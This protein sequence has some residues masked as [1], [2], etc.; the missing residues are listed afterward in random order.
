EHAPDAIMVF[1]VEQDR[2]IDANAPAEKLF[3]YPRERLLT[4][5]PLDFCSKH[6]ADGRPSCEVVEDENRKVLEGG[7][8]VFE[9]THV[10][11]TGREIACHVRLSRL[12]AVGR[13]LIR[14][15]MTDISELKQLE[16]KV[17]HADRLAAVGALAAGVAH[18]IGNPLMALSM[19]AQSLERRSCD[20]YTQKKLALIREH[21]DRISR[22]VRQMNDL[23][24]P[25][26]GVRGR[27]D[28]NEVVRR[29]VEMVRYDNRAKNAEVRYELAE[30]L[31]EVEAV[32]D[33]LTQVCI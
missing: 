17:R 29:A 6:Q 28:V 19:A 18:E 7:T 13:K 1:D 14:V 33:E 4:M 30:G 21:I 16:Q 3:G 2:F 8:S 32:E 9:F 25:H 10:D 11:A 26:S 27:C 24:R 31:P 12:P 5:G 15:T 20:E 23:A 22:I